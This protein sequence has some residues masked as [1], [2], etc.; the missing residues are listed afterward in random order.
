MLSDESGLIDTRER[1]A[2]ALEHADV[3]KRPCNGITTVAFD[4]EQRLYSTQARVSNAPEIRLSF[5]LG[6]TRPLF[7]RSACLTVNQYLLEPIKSS[8][9]ASLYLRLK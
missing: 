3:E 5:R 8:N 2:V 9:F 1:N 6:L 7:T 4:A